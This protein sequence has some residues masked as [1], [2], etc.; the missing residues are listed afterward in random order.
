MVIREKTNIFGHQLYKIVQ[1][2]ALLVSEIKNKNEIFY[3]LSLLVSV[4]QNQHSFTS[5]WYHEPIIATKLYS[6]FL[7]LG[8]CCTNR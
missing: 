7:N 6:I 5:L 4:R 1:R 8:Y 2:L 3:A